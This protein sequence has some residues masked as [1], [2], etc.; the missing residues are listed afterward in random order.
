MKLLPRNKQI[1][2]IT[3]F[4][5]FR[6]RLYD[7][8]ITYELQ[9]FYFQKLYQSVGIVTKLIEFR[10]KVFVFQCWE[11][12]A[13]CSLVIWR[14]SLMM[15]SEWSSYWPEKSGAKTSSLN[16]RRGSPSTIPAADEFKLGRK[17]PWMWR[18]TIG[19]VGFIWSGRVSVTQDDCLEL[20]V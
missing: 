12:G 17:T 2:H 18:K 11:A 3:V 14:W 7:V 5:I 10:W 16:K 13:G 19:T 9:K 1:R 15:K 4:V 6:D 8:I 20:S